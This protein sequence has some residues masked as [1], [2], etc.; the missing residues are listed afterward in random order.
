MIFFCG[1]SSSSLKSLHTSEHRISPKVIITRSVFSQDGDNGVLYGVLPYKCSEP[2]VYQQAG[3][4]SWPQ[5][6]QCM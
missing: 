3:E 2:S 1:F 6:C 4:S 5:V